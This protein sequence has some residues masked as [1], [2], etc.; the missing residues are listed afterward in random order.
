M[1]HERLVILTIVTRDT[2]LVPDDQRVEVQQLRPDIYRVGGAYG[3]MEQ[4][5]VPALLEKC[6]P[7]GLAIDSNK[8]TFFLSRET[9]IP[10]RDSGMQPWRRRLFATM[11]R[12]AQSAAAFFRLPPNRVVELGMQVEI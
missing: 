7:H 10:G 9:V 3:F 11:S 5:N 4:P 2:P 6:A 8:T 12:N 1:L